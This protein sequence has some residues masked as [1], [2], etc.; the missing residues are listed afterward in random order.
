MIA[1][2]LFKKPA[3][4]VSGGYQRPA[5]WIAMPSI[6][7]SEQKVAALFLVGDN[8]S[9]F[10][11]FRCSGAYTVDWGDGT[12]ENIAS[13]TTAQ[14]NYVY[15]DLSASTEFGP[16]GSKSRQAMI[17]I[18]PQAGQN[19]TSTSF[20]FRHSSISSTYTTP[21]LEIVASVPNGSLLVGG[22]LG[23][24]RLL[25]QCTILSHNINSL[26]TMFTNCASLQSI[27]LFDTSNIT[28]WANAF[29]FCSSLK[30][31]PL[32]DTSSA[33][34]LQNFFS[35]C[36]SLESIPQFNT[37]NVS[38]FIGCFQ[39]CFALKEIPEIDT[40]AGTQLT[41]MFYNCVALKSIPLLATNSAIHMNN[42]FFNCY[43]LQSIPALN[44][45]SAVSIGNFARDVP[46]LKRCLAT[47]IKATTWINGTLSSDALNEIYTNLAPVTGQTITVT[48]NYGTAGDD[49]TIATAKGWTVTG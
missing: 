39:S 32:F 37:S 14:H 24:P 29:A 38:N 46:G 41:S 9:N 11:A 44:C 26:S 28:N 19:L 47:G 34:N 8:N 30:T 31:V 10:I 16:T 18:T 48:G 15:S 35:N 43:S 13:N 23:N 7:P 20:N 21:I 36:Y 25:E 45:S 22:T 1:T 40:S 42:M 27:P 17:V 2:P 3:A 4:A 5:A 49:P 12:T 6:D 33:T